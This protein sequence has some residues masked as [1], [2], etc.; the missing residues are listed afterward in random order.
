[1]SPFFDDLERQLHDAARQRS[2]PALRRGWLRAGLGSVPVLAAVALAI[3]VAVGGFALLGHGSSS[4]PASSPPTPAQLAADAR[5]IRQAVQAAHRLPV[6]RAGARARPVA[7]GAAPSAGLLRILGVLRRP[8][9]AADRPPPG[10]LAGLSHVYRGY[11]RRGVVVD[12]VSY[13]VVPIEQVDVQGL[14]PRC[15]AAEVAALHRELPRVP[16][17]Q[18][19]GLVALNARL[20]LVDT[21]PASPQD[22]VCLEHHGPRS[23]GGTCGA[24]ALGVAHGASL[25]VADGTVAGIVPDGVSQVT[26]TYRVGGSARAESVTA[27]V[28]ANM[29]AVP[30]LRARDG[31]QPTAIVWH[32]AGGQA[33]RTI[34]PYRN[35][36]SAFCRRNPGACAP[37]QSEESSSSAAAP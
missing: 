28:S 36:G 17:A 24:T 37:R 7:A 34:R 30:M 9:T 35:G 10:L 2:S 19:A 3:L 20:V 4:P 14:S 21:R 25:T 27:P 23:G 26:L 18:R 16:G 15:A 6:C 5:Y 32:A 11:V 33:I 31:Q 8:A 22:V 1:M 13:W 12:G 29:F